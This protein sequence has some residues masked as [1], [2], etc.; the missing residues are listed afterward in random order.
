M[1]T[2]TVRELSNNVIQVTSGGTLDTTGLGGPTT[3]PANPADTPLFNAADPA[4]FAGP[5][6]SVSYNIW[7]VSWTATSTG[8]GQPGNYFGTT[9]SS[10]PDAIAGIDPLFN[11]IL[12][13][14]SCGANALCTIAQSIT[15]FEPGTP[16][17]LTA[18]TYTW[19]WGAGADQ[20]IEITVIPVP[21]PLPALGAAAAFGW[22]R[23]LRRRV[24]AA[25]PGARGGAAMP[26]LP[27]RGA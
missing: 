26:P 24:A 27:R 5:F 15:T 13:P 23:R 14:T 6:G 10:D 19:A 8:F 12:T 21:G 18:G 3:Q 16:L 20:R 11:Q 17:N 9:T 22:S 1:L 2:F 4:I 7:A 25:A